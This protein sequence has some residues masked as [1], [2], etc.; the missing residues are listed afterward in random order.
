MRGFFSIIPACLFAFQPLFGEPTTPIP[1]DPHVHNF[2]ET[3][4]VQCHGV[5]KAKG[6]RAFHELSFLQNGTRMVDL[7]HAE[8]RNL[9]HDILDQLN[10]GEM[11][12]K[13]KGVKQPPLD[14]TRKVVAWLT[15]TLLALEEKE[16]SGHAVIRRL[17]RREYRNTLHD[18]LG[19]GNLTIDPTLNFP[20]DEMEEG[21]TNIGEA[22]NL[23]D[24]HLDQYLNASGKYLDIA[25]QFGNPQPLKTLDLGD[26]SQWGFPLKQART[27]WAYR[28]ATPGKY[29]DI[30]N[31]AKD[32]TAHI[33]QITY[34]PRFA[35]RGGIQTPGY[36]KL[37]LRAE[38]I[39]RLTHPYDPKMIPAD[40]TQPMQLGLY[41]SEGKEGTTA[42]GVKARTRIGLWELGDNQAKNYSVTVWLEKGAVPFLNW[43]NGPGPS[44]WWM[45]DICKKYHDDIEFRG[46]QGALAWHIVGKNAVPGRIISDV[47]KGPLMRIHAFDVTGPLPETYH[48]KAKTTYLGK[49]QD[50]K[51]ALLQ[52]TRK[53]FRRPV[54][55]KD[56]LPFLRI[57]RESKQKLGL[58]H[59]EAL[60]AAFQAVLVSPDFLY[61][62]ETGGEE[63]RLTPH[64]L[65]NR[66]SYFLWS[67]MPDDQLFQLAD[68]GKLRQPSIL[69][70]QALRML[71]GP[72]SRALVEGFAESWLRLDKLGTMPPDNQKFGSY[73]HYG[74]E[75]AMREETHQFLAYMLQAN[76]PPREFVDS[77]YLFANQSLAKLYGIEGVTGKHFRKVQLPADSPRGGLLG[78]AS[79]LTLSANG[80][81]TSPVVRGIW[82][83]ENLLGTPPPP[84]PPDVEPLDPDVRGATTLRQRLEK[85]RSVEACADCHSN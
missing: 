50:L 5:E 39:R 20:A 9:L 51:Q 78:Q 30:G 2:I 76:R 43:D 77:G 23:T 26:N 62:K 36:Y 25:I 47:W 44:D 53:A 63:G 35:N 13:K 17:N 64:E 4:C 70:Q 73:Y 80:V 54:S 71:A 29:L 55:E 83:L 49:G 75:E 65:A 45:R 40:L 81:D 58:N 66:L 46:K 82:V 24:A 21:F 84:P 7:G 22:L 10:L 61:L 59:Q 37:S 68:S 69:H 27:P 42:S 56:V 11:P 16:H 57:Y 67:S 3:Y 74:L 1:F 12:P 8:S 18:L 19:L 41:I 34:P 6:D 32:L 72:K 79:I 28:L 60:K 38:A 33:Y 52:F 15:Q 48:S 85:H 14:D 31:G